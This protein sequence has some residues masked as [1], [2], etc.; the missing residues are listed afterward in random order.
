L[1]CAGIHLRDLVFIEE[2]ETK[3]NNMVNMEKVQ[4]IA[5]VLG[6]ALYVAHKRSLSLCV[7]V[8]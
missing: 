1:T 5:H 6:T 2:L 7:C 4:L 8:L 3:R